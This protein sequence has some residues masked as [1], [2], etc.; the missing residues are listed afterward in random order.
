[1]KQKEVLVMGI[2]EINNYSNLYNSFATQKKANTKA[3]KETDK[4]EKTE[5]NS[6]LKL[7]DSAKKLLEELKQTYGNMDF[8]VANYESDEEAAAYLA[9]GTKEYSVLIEPE[10]LEEMAANEETKEKYL[11]LLNNA[12]NEITNIKEQLGEQKEEVTHIGIV[13]GE[14][15]T[16]SYFAELEKTSEK[17]RERIEEAKEEKAEE[18]KA[19]QEKKA[20]QEKK[21]KTKVQA[22]SIEE[23]LEKIKNVDWSKVKEDRETEIGSKFDLVI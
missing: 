12:T 20:M 19:V 15:G 5:Q 13:F 11:D 1:M 7:S 21:K 6:Q 10:V 18:D 22:S 4:A 17:Q 3:S 16:I 14:D 2:T 8:M 23:L 9:R